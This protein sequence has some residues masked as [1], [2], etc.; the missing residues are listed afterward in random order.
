M[1]L[2]FVAGRRVSAVTTDFLAWCSQ[3][4]AAQG[5]IALLLIQDNAS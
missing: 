4:L 5:I 1:L 2:R 3:R